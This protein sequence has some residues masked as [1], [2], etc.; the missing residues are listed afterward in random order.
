[1]LKRKNMEEESIGAR[2]WLV[3][4]LDIF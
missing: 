1:L 4:D 2:R 3:K